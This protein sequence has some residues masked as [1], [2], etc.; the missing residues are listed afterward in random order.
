MDLVFSPLEVAAVLLSVG[1]IIIIASNGETNWFEGVLLLSV[2]AILS[3]GFFYIPAVAPRGYDAAGE[4]VRHEQAPATASGT[5][6]A[7]EGK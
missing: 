4:A 7:F 2:Y 1:I 5:G 3:I 6:H